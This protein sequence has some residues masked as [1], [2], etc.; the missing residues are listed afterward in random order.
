MEENLKHYNMDHTQK[1]IHCSGYEEK[2]D[3]KSNDKINERIAEERRHELLSVIESKINKVKKKDNCG[4]EE[5]FEE[6]K[7]EFTEYVLKYEFNREF[8]LS[9]ELA[10]WLENKRYPEKIT[11][12][13][14]IINE[15]LLKKKSS[16]F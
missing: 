9:V 6:L 16:T 15:F 3:H 1:C 2:I 4:Y 7:Y 11:P 14:Q 13:H 5:L 10:I 8:N 12:L